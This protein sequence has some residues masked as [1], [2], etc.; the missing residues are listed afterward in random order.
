MERLQKIL[1]HAG[2]ASRRKCEE[3]ILT[4]RV[5]V[6]GKI[7]SE[8]GTKVDPARDHI[9]VD[10][11]PI[12]IE[13]KTYIALHKPRGYL[14]D[15]AKERGQKLAVDLVP[16]HE[17]LYA[18]GRLDL[19]SEG[20]LLLT[21]D[22]DL[23]HRVT[24]PRFE[25]EKEYL[26]LVEGEPDD[27]ALAKLL[28]GVWYDGEVLRADHVVRVARHQRFAS[29]ARGQTWLK[30]VLHEGRKRHI[31]HLCAG[32]GHSVLRLIRVRIGPIDL[33]ALPVGKWRA[34]SE[35][36]VRALATGC[37]GDTGRRKQRLHLP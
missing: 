16:S 22:G 28:K 15:I 34:L 30:I 12:R 26:A 3:L 17:R 14:S 27:T 11:A 13:Q 36:E 24:H 7:V 9:Q 37:T 35:Y 33:G 32:I 23:A 21:N 10:G 1:A 4:G 29:A 6:N 19:N 18:A 31:R 2:I 20:L 25:H 5:R 8:L